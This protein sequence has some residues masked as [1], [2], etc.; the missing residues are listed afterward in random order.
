M[1]VFLGTYISLV[2]LED[3]SLLVELL[4]PVLVHEVSKPR[5][6]AHHP[7]VSPPLVVQ[8]TPESVSQGTSPTLAPMLVTSDLYPVL[9]SAFSGQQGL[10]FPCVTLGLCFSVFSLAL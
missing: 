3:T 9:A 5:P 10:A 6:C 2:Y 8:L 1:R 4:M 7:A